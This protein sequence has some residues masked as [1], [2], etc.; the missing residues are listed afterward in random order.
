MEVFIVILLDFE[1]KVLYVEV[2]DNEDQINLKVVYRNQMVN[3]AAKV[4][5]EIMQI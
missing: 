2:L 4:Y 5:G 3:Y 1:E